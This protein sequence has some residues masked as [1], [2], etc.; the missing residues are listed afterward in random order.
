VLL[1][2]ERGCR[3]Q[4]QDAE[5]PDYEVDNNAHRFLLLG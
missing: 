3:D 1:G 2:S 4:G 5:N